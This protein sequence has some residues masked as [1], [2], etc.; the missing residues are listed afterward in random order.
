MSGPDEPSSPVGGGGGRSDGSAFLLHGSAGAHLV[1]DLDT[2]EALIRRRRTSMLVDR[3]RPVSPE[4]VGR[5]CSIAQ[6]APNHKRTWPWRFT[7][8]EGPARARLGTVISGAMQVHGDPP[9]KVEK[10]RTKYL[11]TPAVLIIGAIAGDSAQRTAENRD[12]V[13]AAIQNLLLAATAADLATYWG[14][15]PMG[16]NDVVADFAG[17]DHGTHVAGIIYVG[18]AMS[19]VAAP[20]RPPVELTVLST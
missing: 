18:W 5:L 13:A 4:L 8:V 17:F 15:C 12:A 2:L 20:D 11:R 1:V 9:E 10:A 7:L 16:A 14:S 3:D 6:W 19:E